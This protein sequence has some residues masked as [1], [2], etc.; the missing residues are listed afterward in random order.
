MKAK[1]IFP[2]CDSDDLSYSEEDSS[3]DPDADAIRKATRVLT[4]NA[5][6]RA[7]NAV[8]SNPDDQA[9]KK[10][11][12]LNAGSSDAEV[13][14]E[15][16]ASSTT[17]SPSLSET[18]PEEP[19]AIETHVAA[20]Q[21]DGLVT[22]FCPKSQQFKPLYAS[23][24]RYRL[25]P[26]RDN[27]PSIDTQIGQLKMDLE[28][29]V[30]LNF[31]RQTKQNFSLALGPDRAEKFRQLKNIETSCAPKNQTL[32]KNSELR[33]LQGGF[34]S[35]PAE[36]FEV[37]R[38]DSLRDLTTNA[39]ITAE[40]D[41][42]PSSR[43]SSF[44]ETCPV[45]QTTRL[46]AMAPLAVKEDTSLPSKKQ[47]SDSIGSRLPV[48]LPKA[49]QKSSFDEILNS[50]GH[51]P[52]SNGGPT[53]QA[54]RY[55]STSKYSSDSLAPTCALPAYPNLS[56]SAAH[57]PKQHPSDRFAKDRATTPFLNKNQ[58]GN[59][60]YTPPQRRIWNPPVPK[61][62]V[63]VSLR[64]AL[65]NR[66]FPPSPS[67]LLKRRIEPARP[68]HDKRELTEILTNL[69]RKLPPVR[70]SADDDVYVAS[71][72]AGQVLTPTTC[73]C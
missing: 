13:T 7:R 5:L 14:P 71:V 59:L 42:P 19:M 67:K 63:K 37:R 25:F 57:F 36:T 44:D 65:E 69:K 61:T 66:E 33:R 16:S 17:S 45:H 12:T 6:K 23:F 39:P 70:D 40:P 30:T 32:I 46:P 43:R 4:R 53:S 49:T 24:T 35:P 20:Y 58:T 27:E 73:T 41:F 38:R 10:T 34:R 55:G 29:K 72:V 11:K 56:R 18:E 22:E 28:A 48:L 68:C 31:D 2:G 51:V 26:S 54:Y 60:V 62:P 8:S 50:L 47:K 52:K 1:K 3:I 64:Q 21:P 15:T 9:K